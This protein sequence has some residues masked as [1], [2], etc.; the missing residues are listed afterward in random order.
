ME[1]G[2][3]GDTPSGLDGQTCSCGGHSPLQSCLSFWSLVRLLFGTMIGEKQRD[4]RQSANFLP[5]VGAGST[6]PH[7]VPECGHSH[8]EQPVQVPQ[9][10][11]TAAGETSGSAGQVASFSAESST[12]HLC[13][14][15]PPQDACRPAPFSWHSMLPHAPQDKRNPQEGR[16]EGRTRS[17]RDNLVLLESLCGSLNN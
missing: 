1:G 12:C 16:K 15:P 5:L 10:G 17:S 8:G 2:L 7:L 9:S 11:R 4:G 13:T 14:P 3:S 6:G